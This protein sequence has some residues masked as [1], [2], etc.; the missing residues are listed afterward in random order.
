[1]LEHGYPTPQLPSSTRYLSRPSP[2]ALSDVVDLI[3]DRG[4]VIDAYVRVAVLGI[5][6]ATI[7]AR[8]AVASVDTYL[9]FAE[10][11]TRLDLAETH[12][13]PIE[14][15]RSAKPRAKTAA[16]GGALDALSDEI[17]DAIEDGER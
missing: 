7:D 10:A 3:L 14:F 2:S 1:M 5:E 8:V 12:E 4:L 16:V 13:T 17:K 6:V 9:R 11:V 15:A